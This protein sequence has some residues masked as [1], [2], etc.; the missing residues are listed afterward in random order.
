MAT[1][2]A[3][4]GTYMWTQ[5]IMKL[6]KKDI[7]VFGQTCDIFYI[8]INQRA[9]F[10]AY[11]DSL[12][13]RDEGEE[14]EEPTNTPP[15]SPNPNTASLAHTSKSALEYNL[16]RINSDDMHHIPLVCDGQT[17][18]IS[19][20]H[21][22]FRKENFI[23]AALWHHLQSNALQDC[24]FTG[25]PIDVMQSLAHVAVEKFDENVNVCHII[26]RKNATRL[27]FRTVRRERYRHAACCKNNTTHSMCTQCHMFV[28][29]ICAYV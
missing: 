28:M 10:Y 11:R 21:K 1:A 7:S 15:I 19:L 12:D 5:P 23:I 20:L 13:E 25:V 22:G 4:A 9:I 3:A 2:A 8:W 24:G 26:F 6:R 16:Q 18:I 14:T 17:R 27:M 29:T